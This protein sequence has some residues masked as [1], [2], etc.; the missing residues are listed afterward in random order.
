MGLF[1]CIF[2]CIKIFYKNIHHLLINKKLYIINLIDVFVFIL[3]YPF[4]TK[5]CQLVSG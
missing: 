2:D 1:I 3:K 5:D 4:D